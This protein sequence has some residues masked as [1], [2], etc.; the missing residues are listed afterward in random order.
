MFLQ[1][2]EDE[3]FRHLPWLNPKRKLRYLYLEYVIIYMTYTICLYTLYMKI[4]VHRVY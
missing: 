2:M 3:V 4:K 1:K